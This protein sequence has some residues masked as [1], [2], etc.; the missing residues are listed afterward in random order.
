[1]VWFKKHRYRNTDTL[2]NGAAGRGWMGAMVLPPQED[3]LRWKSL[4]IIS[5]VSRPP[6]APCSLLHTS[7]LQRTSP[8]LDGI[9]SLN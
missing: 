2:L 3:A 1:M 4:F 6:R 5:S 8:S 9:Q 7:N